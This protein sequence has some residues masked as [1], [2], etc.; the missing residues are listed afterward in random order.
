[1]PTN[2]DNITTRSLKGVP[3]YAKSVPEEY[4]VKI[5][6]R[7]SCR[8]PRW[9]ELN[10]A[11]PGVDEILEAEIGEYKATCLV[12]GHVADDSYNWNE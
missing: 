11:H 3:D 8:G 4:L 6:C 10:K 2:S 1:M 5:F 12:C 7:G 9:G